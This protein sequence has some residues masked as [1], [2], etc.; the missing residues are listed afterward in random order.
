MSCKL[1]EQGRQKDQ[2]ERDHLVKAGM[3]CVQVNIVSPMQFAAVL[4][5]LMRIQLLKCTNKYF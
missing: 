4:G 2:T 3:C 1:L 5:T